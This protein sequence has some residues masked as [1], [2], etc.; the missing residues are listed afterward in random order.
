MHRTATSKK[1]QSSAG[2]DGKALHCSYLLSASSLWLA[3]KAAVLLPNAATAVISKAI[4]PADDFQAHELLKSLNGFQRE[5]NTILEGRS[6][7]V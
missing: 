2:A 3:A 1:Q 5:L 7:V 6:V 4:T